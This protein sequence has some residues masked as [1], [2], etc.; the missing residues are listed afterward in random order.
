[1][2]P[3][4]LSVA[5]VASGGEAIHARL[6]EVLAAGIADG[7]V[8]V[9]DVRDRPGATD[10]R[11]RLCLAPRGSTVPRLRA[12]GLAAAGA[13][14]VAIT[15]SFCEPAAGWTSTLLESAGAN[16]S[17][18][19]GGPIDRLE[20]RAGEWAS[21][22][23]E[24]GRFLPGRGAGPVDELAG[25]NVAYD[26]ERLRRAL[27]GLPEEIYEVELHARLRASGETLWHEPR[28]V[29]YDASHPRFRRSL[30]AQRLHGRLHA[31]R[32]AREIPRAASLLRGIAA[33]VVPALLFTRLARIAIARDHGRAFARASLPLALLLGAWAFGEGQGYLLGAGSAERSWI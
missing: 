22:F 26:R 31:G 5:V 23:C 1:M 12:L 32:R 4:E 14:R 16:G 19:V 24:Y 3:P 11:A 6:F 28:A 25:I 29:L 9:L 20:G 2:S 33:P 8:E 18:A 27:G 21:T 15:E 10:P 13:G 7:S 30:S 17:A